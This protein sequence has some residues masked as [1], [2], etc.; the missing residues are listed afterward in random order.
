MK[1]YCSGPGPHDPPDGVLGEADHEVDGMLCNS[2][3]CQPVSAPEAP[4]PFD[5]L[6]EA[7]A[8]ATTISKLRAVNDQLI[9]LLDPSVPS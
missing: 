7:N 2:P 8:A 5:E 6:R 9:D 1:L 4:S 3:A